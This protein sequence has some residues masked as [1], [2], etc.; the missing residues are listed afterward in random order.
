MKAILMSAALMVG[1]GLF[2]GRAS[3]ALPEVNVVQGWYAQFLHR[4]A[5]PRCQDLMAAQLRG[6]AD[7]DDVLAQILGSDEYYRLNGCCPEGFVVGLYRD[8]LGEQA[9]RD[10]INSW[11]C[12]LRRCGSRERTA[13]DFLRCIHGP[14]AVPPVP[15]VPLPPQDVPPTLPRY[16][17]REAPPRIVYVPVP[18]RG[19]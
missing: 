10:Q 12:A 13:R 2:P 14:D 19:R 5:D 15:D 8:A 17:P 16:Y 3:A 9:S 1:L 4:R 7:P 6:G 11:T 18:V